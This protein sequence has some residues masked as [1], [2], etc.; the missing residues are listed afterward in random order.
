MAPGERE[1]DRQTIPE[2]D[3]TSGLSRSAA[4]PAKQGRVLGGNPPQLG[5]QPISPN[6]GATALRP[7]AAVEPAR[8]VARHCER[9]A[10][11]VGIV[12]LDD[13]HPILQARGVRFHFATDKRHYAIRV[14]LAEFASNC[15]RELCRIFVK[16]EA[17]SADPR[18]STLSDWPLK[19]AKR[20]QRH[21]VAH[22]RVACSFTAASG[23][24]S[25]AQR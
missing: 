8:L 11:G 3:P 23:P 15:K 18:G 6:G 17:S 16:A 22:C 2:D 7:Q 9:A 20:A 1:T 25:R 4:G 24:S 13:R 12:A 10:P 5:Q 19:Q 14:A 21:L